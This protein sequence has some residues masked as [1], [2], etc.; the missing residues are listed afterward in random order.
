VNRIWILAEQRNGV[1]ATISL[2][3][4]AAARTLGATAEAV[5]WGAGA[6]STAAVLGDHG[7]TR[8]YDAGDLGESLAGPRVAAAVSALIDLAGAPDAIFV[9]QTHDGRDIA[10][11]LSARLD[12]PVLTNIVGL[13]EEGRSILTEHTIF[14]GRQ[15]LTAKFTGDGPGIFVIR[16]KSFAAQPAGGTEPELISIELPD[17]RVT[18]AARVRNRYEQER[19]GPQ[20][21]QA[22]V[23]VSGGRGLGTAEN[24]ALV[25]ELAKLL[26][27]A[28][29]ASRA[30]VDAGWVPYS[31]Q[32]GQTGKTVKPTVYIACGISG[33][34]QHVVGMKNAKHIIAINK[35]ES[36]PIFSVSDLGIIGDVHIVLPKLIESLRAR[37]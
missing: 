1:P 31:H 17:T 22:S 35:D 5:T 4:L 18:D 2:E 6:A 36:A 30:I 34:T 29:G 24:Y 8:I 15:V 7:A 33:A 26:N 37:Q 21:D 12:R 10:G 28:P 16:A 14:G 32:V 20:L 13:I 19:D 27:G 11:R 3:L 25:E 23:V 9:G